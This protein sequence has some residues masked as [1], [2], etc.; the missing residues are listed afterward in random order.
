MSE[1]EIQALLAQ[2]Q[3]RLLLGQNKPSWG[4]CRLWQRA[5]WRAFPSML[6]RQI[7]G[8]RF[9]AH[10]GFPKNEAYD[11]RYPELLP[12]GTEDDLQPNDSASSIPRYRIVQ[13][14]RIGNPSFLTASMSRTNHGC[15]LPPAKKQRGIAF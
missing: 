9:V 4:K 10:H 3:V 15:T 12:P 8:S 2:Q 1:R 14:Y 6:I 7:R 11:A 13:P 5:P